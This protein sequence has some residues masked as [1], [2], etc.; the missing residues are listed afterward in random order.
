MNIALI[1][2]GYWGPNIL[3]SFDGTKN[4][5]THVVDI[6][7]ENLKRARGYRSDLILMKSVDEVVASSDIDA[8]VIALPTGVHY[9]VA[10]KAILNGKHVMIEK[11]M[12]GNLETAT[13]LTRLAKENGV[14][15]MVD[16]NYVYKKTVNDIKKLYERGIIG[17]ALYYD[18]SRQNLGIFRPQDDVI[19]DLAP[20]DIA[21]VKHILG[22]NPIAVS[23][24]A[25]SH[26]IKGKYDMASLILFFED[27]FIANIDVSWIFPK[28]ERRVYL[29]GD[30]LVARF[31]DSI[32]EQK[33]KLYPVGY[34]ACSNGVI[35]TQDEPYLY[36]RDTENAITNAGNDFIYCIENNKTPLSSAEFGCDVVRIIE[37]LEKSADLGGQR[38]EI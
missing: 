34:E 35:C 11:P 5:I 2:Y 37:A 15:L 30:K 19:W 20:H 13:D 24:T 16:H 18:A 4:K 26:I 8:V 22:K 38:I 32:E 29:G 12:T 17:R 27:E 14:V 21:I 25:A 31:D 33:L 3:K 23:A 28:K 10:K 9:E 7:E 6:N 36:G 1:G